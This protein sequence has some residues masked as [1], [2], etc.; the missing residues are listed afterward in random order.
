MN[1]TLHKTSYKKSVKKTNVFVLFVLGSTHR[2]GVPVARHVDLAQKVELFSVKPMIPHQELFSTYLTMSAEVTN[3][4]K[5]TKILTL[6][7]GLTKY[8]FQSNNQNQKPPVFHQ[9]EEWVGRDPH[10]NKFAMGTPPP[11]TRTD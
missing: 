1:R 2:I 3:L 11:P 8:M 6:F 9:E 7:R 5:V 4:R 10:V